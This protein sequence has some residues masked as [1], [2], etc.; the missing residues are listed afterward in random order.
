MSH[1]E[2]I[3]I[4]MLHME[5]KGFLILKKKIKIPQ[6]RLKKILEIFCG[7]HFCSLNIVIL[8][9]LIFSAEKSCR[10]ETL[11]CSLMGGSQKS[12]VF[13][14]YNVMLRVFRVHI[15]AKDFGDG[16]EIARCGEPQ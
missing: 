6:G 9:Y 11:K 10:S 5:K 13:F 14:C 4:L 3:F 15:S 8:F 12:T 16:S 2:I 7:R 1:M